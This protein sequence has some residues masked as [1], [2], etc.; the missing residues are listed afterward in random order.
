MCHAATFLISRVSNEIHGKV[1]KHWTK[2]AMDRFPDLPEITVCH[3]YKIN[4][5]FTFKCV[6]CDYN[7]SSDND[8]LIDIIQ[9]ACGRCKGNFELV[10][11]KRKL[12]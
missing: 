6:D 12:K 8:R 3:S 9:E 11:N 10:E 7:I 2:K 5:K 1:W 4:K